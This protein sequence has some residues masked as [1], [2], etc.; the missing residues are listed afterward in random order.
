M[1][2]TPPDGWR[3]QPALPLALPTHPLKRAIRVALGLVIAALR[4]QRL[5]SLLTALDPATLTTADRWMLS[6]HVHRQTLR[7]D[8][9]LAQRIHKAF[10]QSEAAAEWMGGD[11]RYREMF[12]VHHIG[13]VDPLV[14]AARA[15]GAKRLHEIGCGRGDVLRHMAQAMPFLQS[16]TGLDLNARLLDDARQHTQDPRIRFVATD[17]SQW[18]AEN[19]TA[20]DIVLTNGGVY[21]YWTQSQLQ[22][23]FSRLSQLRPAVVAL[24]EPLNPQ[25]DFSTQPDSMPYGYE[26]SLSHNYPALLQACGFTVTFQQRITLQGGPY[27]W[28]LLVA[29]LPAQTS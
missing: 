11:S 7:G 1:T 20:Q 8:Q 14:A 25:H 24:V 16:L 22:A 9:A 15:M 26:G 13:I 10:W 3:E 6:A 27:P 28:L 5:K 29:T 21:E 18:L 12:L 23:H 4:P 19:A 17:A 2:T